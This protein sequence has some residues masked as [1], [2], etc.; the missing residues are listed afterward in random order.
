LDGSASGESSPLDTPE[1]VQCTLEQ[2]LST[3]SEYEVNQQLADDEDRDDKLLP[4]APEP[5]V[6]LP[7]PE[8]NVQTIP[9]PYMQHQHKSHIPIAQSLDQQAIVPFLTVKPTLKLR[10]PTAATP[11]QI[12]FIPMA[13]VP[14]PSTFEGKETENPQNFL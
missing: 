9:F 2:E 10:T 12:P 4:G 8:P 13:S 7:I 6:I 11:P 1:T 5:S 3:K 14:A